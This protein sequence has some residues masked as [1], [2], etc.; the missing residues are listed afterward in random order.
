MVPTQFVN[1]ESA[2]SAEKLEK[3]PPPQK[4]NTQKDKETKNRKLKKASRLVLEAGNETILLY[5]SHYP[6]LLT[7]TFCL[8]LEGLFDVLYSL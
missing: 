2:L 3:P 6:P 8:I 5:E 1:V 4:K 7:T